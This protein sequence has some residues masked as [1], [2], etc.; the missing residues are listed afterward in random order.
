M[1]LFEFYGF[2]SICAPEWNC[3]LCGVCPLVSE[4][5]LRLQ[6]ASWRAGPEAGTREL[7]S[8]LASG[9]Q[10]ACLLMGGAA[11]PTQLVVREAMS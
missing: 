8:V 4:T 10:A 11:S 7:G 6:P 2:V 1:C 9:L 3:C 5:G